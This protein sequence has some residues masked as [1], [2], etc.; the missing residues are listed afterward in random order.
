[1]QRAKTRIIR[2]GIVAGLVGGAVIAGWFFIFD[3][4]NGHPLWSPAMLAAALLHGSQ[5]AEMTQAAWVL[6]AQYSLVHFTAFAIIGAIGALMIDGAT[7]H[8]E[9]FA[10][11]LIFTAAFE[12]FFIALLMLMGPA[13]AAAMPWW[14]VII[15]NLMATTAMLAYF[16]WMQRALARN[17]LGPWI[18]VVR[19][20]VIAGVIGALIVAAWFLIADI[21]A[22]QPFHTPALLGAI[23]FNG[24]HPTGPVTPTAA[25]VLG[26]T[27]LHFFAFIMFGIAASITMVT[28]EYEPLAAL[29]VLVLFVCFE[30]S[31]AG[32]VTFLDQQAIAE[33]GWWNIIGGNV[34]ALAAII[35]YYELG[36]PRVVPRMMER[37]DRMRD[38]PRAEHREAHPETR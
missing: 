33:I 19:E 10:P 25:L 32:F 9:L 15:G 20:G 8:P 7:R 27:A 23:I 36:H 6:V 5:P 17:L 34:V 12:V 24:L 11:L 38:E 18:E 22:G 16:F 31:F 13:A 14:K 37:W 3:L 4:V 28:A 30:V 21:A 2:D 1:M 35:T 29:G 26:Y